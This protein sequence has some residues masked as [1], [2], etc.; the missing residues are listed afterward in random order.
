MEGG[1]VGAGLKQ[2]SSPLSRCASIRNTKL[3]VKVPVA[4][5]W[6]DFLTCESFELI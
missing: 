5:L 4:S 2:P 3:D 1:V 6:A